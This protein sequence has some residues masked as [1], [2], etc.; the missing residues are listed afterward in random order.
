MLTIPLYVRSFLSLIKTVDSNFVSGYM[1]VYF[2]E[3]K[4]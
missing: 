1:L 4:N 3:D 2:I